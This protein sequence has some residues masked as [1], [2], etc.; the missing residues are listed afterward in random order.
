LAWQAS[1]IP[2]PA[3][4]HRHLPTL[5]AAVVVEAV[6]A[7][8]V[9]GVEVEVEAV[10][11]VEAVDVVAAEGVTTRRMIEI[12]RDNGLRPVLRTGPASAGLFCGDAAIAIALG[13][14]VQILAPAAY[15]PRK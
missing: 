12:G 7:E 14:E 15:S 8:D 3:S 13:P 11:E 2:L 1:P 9:A 10:A 5:E 4:R 6:E